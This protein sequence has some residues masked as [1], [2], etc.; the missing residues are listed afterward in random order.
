LSAG[1]GPRLDIVV[2]IHAA[3]RFA[4]TALIDYTGFARTTSLRRLP[5]SAAAHISRQACLVE[6][7]HIEERLEVYLPLLRDV[8]LK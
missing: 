7:E 3:L 1:G 4:T 5:S 6:P 2:P 8:T